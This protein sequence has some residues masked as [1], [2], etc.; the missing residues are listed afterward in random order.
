MT[1]QKT[2]AFCGEP[3]DG[4]WIE[5]RL[6]DGPGLKIGELQLDVCDRHL[7]ETKAA[8][9]RELVECHVTRWEPSKQSPSAW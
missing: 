8:H 9:E 4:S 6:Y 5:L 2:C 3:S 1:D 7:Q